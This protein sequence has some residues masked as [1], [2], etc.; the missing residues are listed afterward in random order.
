M[1]KK[2]QDETHS[3]RELAQAVRL[4]VNALKR[5]H[6]SPLVDD[7]VVAVEKRLAVVEQ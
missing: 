3:D 6:P 7:L 2:T 4:I 5:I 1:S